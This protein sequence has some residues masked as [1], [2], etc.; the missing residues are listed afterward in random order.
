MLLGSL[1]P[2]VEPLKTATLMVEA[3]GKAGNYSAIWMVIPML[4]WLLKQFEDKV[5]CVDKATL[6]DYPNQ[7]AIEDHYAINLKCGWKKLKKYFNKINKT[8]AYYT[9]TLF[10]GN[11]A[12]GRY[13]TPRH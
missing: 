13:A 1:F 10:V 11:E 2:F 3:R 9:T 7:E 6:V 5:A 8:P 12:R 4:D